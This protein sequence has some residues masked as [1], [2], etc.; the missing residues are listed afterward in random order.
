MKIRLEI[1]EGPGTTATYEADGECAIVVGRS[2]RS[3]FPIGTDRRVS[4]V[5]AVIEMGPTGCR[6]RDLKSDNGTFVNGL[7]VQSEELGNGDRILLGES[8]IV[9]W[10]TSEPKNLD[11]TEDAFDEETEDANKDELTQF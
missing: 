11:E 4:R 7:R 8:V 10:L 6:I 2:L 9:V 5:H 3:D 1:V